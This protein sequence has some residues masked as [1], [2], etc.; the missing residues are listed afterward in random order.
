MFLT[1]RT[2]PVAQTQSFSCT[3]LWQIVGILNWGLR[4]ISPK[5]NHIK[6][7]HDFCNWICF[8]LQILLKR[9]YKAVRK[10]R[11]YLN[12]SEKRWILYRK[13]DIWKACK[14]GGLIPPLQ[15]WR[16]RCAP[17]LQLHTKHDSLSPFSDSY[18]RYYKEN[19]WINWWKILF[20]TKILKTLNCHSCWVTTTVFQ[21]IAW[22][23]SWEFQLL[24][25]KC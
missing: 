22:N 2:P 13:A 9:K 1:V 16:G 6:S 11:K 21:K 7:K 12:C 25:I 14:P 20:V 4:E 15:T 17:E 10:Y 8:L 24:L 3:N 18:K 19:V 23:I 5:W